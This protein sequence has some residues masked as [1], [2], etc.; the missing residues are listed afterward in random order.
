[1]KTS[2]SDLISISYSHNSQK[3][4]AEAFASAHDL[5]CQPLRKANSELTLHFGELKLEIIDLQQKMSL[6]VDFIGGSLGHRKKFGGGKGQTIA[7]AIGIKQGNPSPS[8]L[9]ATAGL[10]RDS[11]VFAS[12]GC[13]VTMLERSPIVA[14]LVK[15]GIDR[16]SLNPE[17]NTILEQGFELHCA[18][19]LEYIRQ[20]KE[21]DKP[22]VI[23]LDP[24]YPERKKSASVKKNMQIL[25][26][27]LGHD[28]DTDAVLEAA[29]QKARVRVVVKRPK[30]APVLQASR[31]PTLSYDSKSTR[32]DVYVQPR[33]P[34]SAEPTSA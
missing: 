8:V 2:A 10:A 14:A 1:M 24:M 32:Y 30:G 33:E 31:K 23:Y 27:L 11:F 15:D 17:F 4:A 5:A 21:D 6:E 34:V 26:R 12:L 3:P 18:D 25:Q 7:K 29:L 22:D 20:I 28:L 19:A 9:D 16:A 13:K